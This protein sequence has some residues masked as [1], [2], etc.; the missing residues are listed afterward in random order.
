LVTSDSN[1]FLLNPHRK[2]ENQEQTTATM[3][4]ILPQ[5]TLEPTNKLKQKARQ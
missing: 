4:R 5:P 3:I 2:I 1:N